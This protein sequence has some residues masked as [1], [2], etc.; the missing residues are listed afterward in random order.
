MILLL[1]SVSKF[2]I[3]P[4][5]LEI[6]APGGEVTEIV[7]V[8]NLD[9]THPLRVRTYTGDWFLSMDGKIMYD[10]PGKLPL[11]CSKWIITN[12]SEFEIPPDGKVD[13]RLTI[14]IPDTIKKGHW[15]VVFF[16]SVPIS[17]VWV[18]TIRIA[19]RIGLTVYVSPGGILST[20]GEITSLDYSGGKIEVGFKN[21]GD[22]WLR[23]KLVF[24]AINKGKTARVDSAQAGIVLP[25]YT[26]I[27]TYDF[28]LK[29]GKYTIQVD[30]DYG[31]NEILR[32]EKVIEVR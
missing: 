10:K 19:G 25:D 5:K 13:V 12:P 8:Y 28:S 21:T 16:E 29:P 31:G 7:S 22:I 32:G 1:F 4:P 30:I 26:R 14:T 24:R 23:P 2:L 6:V 9:K 3:T 18:P 11:S 20:G 27:Y 17:E 15:G